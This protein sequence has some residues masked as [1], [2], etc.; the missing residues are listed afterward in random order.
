MGVA[1]RRA[2]EKEE[3]RQEILTAARE[4]FVE[5]GFANVS[6]RRIADKIEFSPTTIYLYFQDKSGLLDCIVE[7]RLVELLHQL[8]ELHDIPLDPVRSLKR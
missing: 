4:M 7:E 1:E 3:L 8:R 2:R 6:M 5:E